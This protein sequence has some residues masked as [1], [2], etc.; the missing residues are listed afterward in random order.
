M[1]Q[2][3]GRTLARSAGGGSE[4][5]GGEEL[6]DTCMIK[7]FFLGRVH[8]LYNRKYKIPSLTRE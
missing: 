2:V 7:C 1:R 5:V 3:L 4:G 8:Q 6:R